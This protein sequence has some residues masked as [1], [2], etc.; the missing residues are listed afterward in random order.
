MTLYQSAEVVSRLPE[1]GWQP[2]PLTLIAAYGKK[3]RVIGINNELPWHLPADL[4]KFKSLTTGRTVIMGRKTHESIGRP[5][6]DRRNIVISRNRQCRWPGCESADSLYAAL[7]LARSGSEGTMSAANN[8]P[9][10]MPADAAVVAEAVPAWQGGRAAHA[11]PAEIFVI[12]GAEIYRQ[13]M[14]LAQ[15]LY[16]TEVACD[17]RGDAYFPPIEETRWKSISRDTYAA[18]GDAPA[19]TFV[20]YERRG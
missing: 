11:V 2:L 16:I 8:R 6:P 13:A 19:Y 17:R 9:I 15:R 5:L 18:A 20:V 4:K 7:E 12:G 1:A 14:P 3:D 10:R